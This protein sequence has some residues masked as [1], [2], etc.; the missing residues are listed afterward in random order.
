MLYLESPAGVGFSYSDDKNY[1]AS[2]DTVSS[3]SSKNPNRRT[4][5][6][7]AILSIRVGLNGQLRCFVGI[8]Y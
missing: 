3:M 1:T 2:D 5:H 4:M 8:L 7:T 6:L